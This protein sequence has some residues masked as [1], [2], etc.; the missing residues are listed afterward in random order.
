MEVKTRHPQI[1]QSDKHPIN[2]KT[3]PQEKAVKG[4]EP[5]HLSTP[6][7]IPYYSMWDIG[8]P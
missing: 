8:T 6:P 3:V 7:S 1:S 2:W 5:S 4:G